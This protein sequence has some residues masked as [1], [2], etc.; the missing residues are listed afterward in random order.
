MNSP[1]R[2]FFIGA[3]IIGCRAAHYLAT[4]CWRDVLMID[5]G[6]LPD[7]SFLWELVSGSAGKLLTS[8][9]SVTVGSS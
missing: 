7:D 9:K 8:F 5:C 1:T 4:P 2:Q 3:D 6:A